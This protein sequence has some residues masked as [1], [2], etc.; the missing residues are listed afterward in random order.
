MTYNIHPLFVHFPIALLF[1]YSVIKILPL[2]KWF[3]KISWRDIERVLLVVGV[4]GAFAAL[5]TGDTAEHLVHPNR[6][7]VQTHENFADLATFLYGA[8]LLGELASFIN[9]RFPS[10]FLKFIERIFCNRGFSFVLALLAL[11]AISLT[12][13]L[14][15]IM[16]YGKTADPFAQTILNLLG[17]NI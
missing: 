7:L 14:G 5:V 17:I 4:L 6:Q 1:V 10:R 15:G 9:E 16:V 8:L 3:P 11:V 2:R 12:G 13:L